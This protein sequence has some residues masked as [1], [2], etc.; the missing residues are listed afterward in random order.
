MI[1][2][3]LRFSLIQRLMILL[4]TAGISAA[5]YWS[6]ENLPIDAFPDISSPQVQVI[7]KA[8]GMTPE[9]VETR[10]TAPVEI[11]LLGIP[12]QTVTAEDQE[13]GGGPVD[14]S[15][16]GGSDGYLE[17]LAQLGKLRDEGILTDEEFEAKKKQI[18]DEN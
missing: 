5:G 11:E 3:I 6:F 9:E 10:I 2:A 16:G 17:E 4:V 8:P 12:E 14:T 18:L 1:A 7:I 13:E 15:D